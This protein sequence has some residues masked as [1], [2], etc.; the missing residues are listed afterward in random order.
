M[1][2]DK[3]VYSTKKSNNEAAANDSFFLKRNTCKT[4]LI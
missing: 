4:H 2:P 1:L 3:I